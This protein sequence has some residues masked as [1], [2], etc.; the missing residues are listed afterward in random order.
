[1][2]RTHGGQQKSH[3]HAGTYGWGHGVCVVVVLVVQP[4][5]P[6]PTQPAARG[7]GASWAGV[8]HENH[9]PCPVRVAGSFA[10]GGRNY[11]PNVGINRSVPL[12]VRGAE[13]S[14]RGRGGRNYQPNAYLIPPRLEPPARPQNTAAFFLAGNFWPFKKNR[15]HGVRC[16]QRGNRAGFLTPDGVPP[17]GVMRLAGCRRQTWLA[18]TRERLRK[19]LR[20]LPRVPTVPTTGCWMHDVSGPR[21]YQLQA[22]QFGNCSLQF[23]SGRSET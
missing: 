10:G 17:G 16:E 19:R 22:L 9:R 18:G 21:R 7:L 4:P 1:M 13:I 20:G 5:Y 12:R 15:V 14:K 3:F 8:H 6:R 11:R 23:D 2:T